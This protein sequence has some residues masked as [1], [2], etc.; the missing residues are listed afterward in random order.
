MES[1]VGRMKMETDQEIARREPPAAGLSA[2]LH[3]SADQRS[4][5][6]KIKKMRSCE[7]LP[8]LFTGSLVCRSRVAKPQRLC[9]YFL[10]MV[11][12]TKP[13]KKYCKRIVR[14]DK[15]RNYF[16][17]DINSS[18]YFI[19]LFSEIQLINNIID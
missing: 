13:R 12:P 7:Q 15:G 14:K 9:A 10:I 8:R 1:S 18:T 5:S 17:R 3:R 4:C 19:Y 6:H 2:C 11:S 16:N